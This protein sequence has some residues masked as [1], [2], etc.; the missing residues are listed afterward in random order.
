V[1]SSSVSSPKK[2]D[3]DVREQTAKRIFGSKTDKV[4]GEWRKTLNKE[5]HGLYFIPNVLGS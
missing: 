5:P 4:T 3:S 1:A 2:T